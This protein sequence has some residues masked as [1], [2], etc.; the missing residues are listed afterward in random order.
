MKIW[1]VFIAAGALTFLMRFLPMN[2]PFFHRMSLFKHE[3]FAILPL[4]I[5]AGLIGPSFLP[6]FQSQAQSVTLPLT[7]IAGGL[8]TLW[9]TRKMNS[10]MWGALAGYVVFIALEQLRP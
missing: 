10:T 3:G 5:L 6:F 9:A 4:C 2:S 1:I 7:L 8:T